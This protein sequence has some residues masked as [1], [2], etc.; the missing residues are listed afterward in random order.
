MCKL[1][2]SILKVVL[3]M[4]ISI[5]RCAPSIEKTL[6]SEFRQAFSSIKHSCH[7]AVDINNWGE[8]CEDNI[9]FLIWI[10]KF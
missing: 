4:Q 8:G 1:L 3:K 5:Y 9:H 2:F 6:W 7:V 10:P